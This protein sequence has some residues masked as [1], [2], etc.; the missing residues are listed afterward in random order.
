M[1]WTSFFF[2]SFSFWPCPWHTEVLGPGFK[3]TLQWRKHWILNPKRHHGI[4]CTRFWSGAQ[5]HGE[6]GTVQHI[7]SAARGHGH[8]SMILKPSARIAA[9]YY[10]KTSSSQWLQMLFLKVQKLASSWVLILFKVFY[11]YPMIQSSNISCKVSMSITI[12]QIMT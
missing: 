2:F 7:H 1:H 9:S 5:S 6:K 10:A 12:S 8:S 4:P 11:M 3:P